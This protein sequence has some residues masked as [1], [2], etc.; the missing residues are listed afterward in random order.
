MLT[1]PRLSN[2][3]L[4]HTR[5]HLVSILLIILPILFIHLLLLLVGGQAV[6]LLCQGYWLWMVVHLFGGGGFALVNGIVSGF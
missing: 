4:S 2:L 3:S 6:L 5:V 1:F